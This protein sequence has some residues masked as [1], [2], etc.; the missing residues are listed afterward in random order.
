VESTP[1]SLVSLSAAAGYSA[2]LLRVWNSLLSASI[3]LKNKKEV[4]KS[5]SKDPCYTK[6]DELIEGRQIYQYNII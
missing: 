3:F 1:L 4:P 6:V 2:K 5:S